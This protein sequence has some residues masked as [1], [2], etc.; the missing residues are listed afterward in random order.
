MWLLIRLSHRKLHVYNTSTVNTYDDVTHLTRTLDFTW[1]IKSLR[2]QISP[3]AGRERERC[4]EQPW[5]IPWVKCQQG[6]MLHA[7]HLF[8]TFIS[9]EGRQKLFSSFLL[10]SHTESKRT[11]WRSNIFTS[12]VWPAIHAT[13]THYFTTHKCE[14]H[15]PQREESCLHRVVKKQ[16]CSWPSLV[17]FTLGE[18][19]FAFPLPFS[20]H[21]ALFLFTSAAHVRTFT[22]IFRPSPRSSLLLSSSPTRVCR[23]VRWALST[24]SH[25]ALAV[26]GSA[27]DTRYSPGA[28]DNDC[29]KAKCPL[30]FTWFELSWCERRPSSNF[31]SQWPVTLMNH[32][33][34]LH[35]VACQ[36]DSQWIVTFHW[37]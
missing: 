4:Y 36:R 37:W 24:N 25:S 26:I 6:E 7:A 13:D 14:L 16:P 9:M 34:Q 12:Q 22:E 29:F 33:R 8:S 2:L 15:W 18:R 17:T 19:A 35:Q 3:A 11:S 28:D 21:R 32:Q 30:D 27:W 1:S 10:S 23:L 20:F 31:T 5:I